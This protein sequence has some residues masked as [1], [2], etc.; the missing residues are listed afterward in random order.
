MGS[1][2]GAHVQKHCVLKKDSKSI[3]CFV[4]KNDIALS[5]QTNKKKSSGFDGGLGGSVGASSYKHIIH[6]W[7]GPQTL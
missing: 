2:K 6:T 1:T 7:K 4:S 5:A 3:V